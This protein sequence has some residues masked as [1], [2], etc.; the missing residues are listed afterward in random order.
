MLL[1]SLSFVYVGALPPFSLKDAE[2]R[3]AFHTKNT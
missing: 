2:G 3:L 1:L